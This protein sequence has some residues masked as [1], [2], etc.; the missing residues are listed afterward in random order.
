MTKK[1]FQFDWF[2]LKII[3]YV[4]LIGIAL[5]C[6]L[7]FYSMIITSTHTNS[8]IARKLLIVP[9]DQFFVNY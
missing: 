8:D 9:G 6:L 3:I 1:A 4:V 7:P 2:I 5:T